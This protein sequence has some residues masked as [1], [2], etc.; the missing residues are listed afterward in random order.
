MPPKF[1]CIVKRSSFVE[2][3]DHFFDD[4]DERVAER[5]Y[6]FNHRSHFPYL[7]ALETVLRYVQKVTRRPNFTYPNI[8]PNAIYPPETSKRDVRVRIIAIWPERFEM[9]HG[10]EDLDIINYYPARVHEGADLPFDSEIFMLQVHGVFNLMNLLKAWNVQGLVRFPQFIDGIITPGDPTLAAIQNAHFPQD[11]M[12]LDNGNFRTPVMAPCDLYTWIRIFEGTPDL[13]RDWTPTLRFILH[14]PGAPDYDFQRGLHHIGQCVNFDD[15]KEQ[16]TCMLPKPP[17][18][19]S[20]TDEYWVEMRQPRRNE[21][22]PLNMEDAVVIDYE[23]P[24][25][26]PDP[27]EPNTTRNIRRP[28]PLIQQADSDLTLTG[29]SDTDPDN[30]DSDGSYASPVPHDPE[31]EVLSSSDSDESVD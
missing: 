7:H 14:P 3:R 29:L 20:P 30:Y 23:D 11:D 5:L 2:L 6:N 8:D 19:E 24:A 28:I 27:D 15:W 16:S 25:T 26:I 4:W 31:Q 18:G 9:L 13:P 22:I 17:V 21:A 10:D 1:N 12:G